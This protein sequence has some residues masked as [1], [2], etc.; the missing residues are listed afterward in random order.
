MVEEAPSGRLF[1]QRTVSHMV[2]GEIH[3]SRSACLMGHPSSNESA[4]SPILAQNMNR[5]QRAGKSV[6]VNPMSTSV[7]TQPTFAMSAME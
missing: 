3:A 7:G 2:Q 1:D 6:E 5:A 4:R